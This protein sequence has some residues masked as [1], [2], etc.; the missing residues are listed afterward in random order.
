[1]V[2]QPVQPTPGAAEAAV[3]SHLRAGLDGLMEELQRFTAPQQQ[4][5]AETTALITQL[6][7]GVGRALELKE[8]KATAEAVAAWHKP[9]ASSVEA[10]MSTLESSAASLPAFDEAKLTRLLGADGE[11]ALRNA[12][13]GLPDQL[14][15][16]VR[17]NNDLGRQ[18]VRLAG[19]TAAGNAQAA[20]GL[21]PYTF[22]L[23]AS[24]LEAENAYMRLAMLGVGPEH[25]QYFLLKSI[26][27]SNEA[28]RTLIVLQGEVLSGADVDGRVPR[29]RW[30]IL[31]ARLTM[32]RP[33]L[34]LRPRRCSPLKT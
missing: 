33:P 2:A 9:W 12:Y 17:G 21:L 25:P 22:R 31:R 13:R 16:L 10:R 7:Q 15:S 20:T 30:P 19:P 28:V 1:M 27:A 6:N 8:G 23:N 26:V 3:Q 24:A 4:V 5:I 11:P 34:S 29:S 32:Q 14:R 18:V